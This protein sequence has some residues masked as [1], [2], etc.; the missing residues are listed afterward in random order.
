MYQIYQIGL[1][2]TLQ[3]IADNFNTTVDELKKIN[4]ITDFSSLGTYIIVP[5]TNNKFEEYTVKKGDSLYSIA[6]KYG[7]TSDTLALINGIDLNEYI[8]PGEKLLIPNE[9][10]KVYI[11]S[12][13]ETL[14]DISNKLNIKKED[15]LN[16]N[17]NLTL[18]PDQIIFYDNLTSM[19]NDN[20]EY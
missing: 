3:S 16:M 4:G 17:E 7:T 6:K 2:D 10:N 11:V 8:Y 14:E 18:M 15:L 12:E 13:N 9:K 20:R 1:Y 19:L 5:N